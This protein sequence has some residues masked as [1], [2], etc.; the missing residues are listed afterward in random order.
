MKQD[1][2][3][4]FRRVEQNLRQSFRVLAAGRAGA[5]VAELPGVSL[6]SLGAAFQMFN[7]AFLSQ[8]IESLTELERRLETMRTHFEA[9]GRPWSFW[10]CED[11][12]TPELRRRLSRTCECAGLRLSSELAG[13]EAERI[14]PP[15]P[16][17]PA[18]DIR[19]VESAQTLEDFR[20]IGS[21]CFHVPIAWFS[22]VFDENVAAHGKFV[23][24]V[25]YSDGLPIA[26]AGTVSCDGV[27]GLYNVATVPKYRG[28]GWGEAITRYAI[29]AA[30]RENTI[31]R[32]ILQSTSQG[33]SLY[34][35]MGFETVTRI[36]VYN[37]VR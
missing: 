1:R 7:A 29:A 36:L 6:A 30:M 32:A 35:K 27:A 22:E 16:R 37:S 15:A 34:R 31:E 28:R 23:C 8:P 10:C 13:M 25:G 17:L 18:L 20:A 9:R 11:W 3:P 14:E 12:L 21:V 24:W 2:A 4:A 33:L 5:D 26:T 19:R